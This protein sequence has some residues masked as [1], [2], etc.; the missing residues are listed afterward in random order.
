MD[1]IRPRERYAFH[2]MGV[3]DSRRIDLSKDPGAGL[4]ALRAAYQ[5][6]RRSGKRFFG[7]TKDGC[8]IIKRL[9]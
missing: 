6:G 2:L 8:M 1:D 7:A 3:N 4:R 5:Y 9:S